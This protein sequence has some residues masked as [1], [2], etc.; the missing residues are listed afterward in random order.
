MRGSSTLVLTLPR[1][2]SRIHRPCHGRSSA[3]P[4]RLPELPDAHPRADRRGHRRRLRALCREVAALHQAFGGARRS[5]GMVRREQA[6]PVLRVRRDHPLLRRVLLVRALRCA[7]RFHRHPAEARV[8][9]R[10]ALSLPDAEALRWL[11]CAVQ[12]HLTSAW[13]MSIDFEDIHKHVENYQ[14][15]IKAVF[16][17]IIS[18]DMKLDV[19]HV[20]S[21]LFRRRELLITCGMSAIPMRV[22]EGETYAAR[23]ELVIELP[24]GWP[25]NVDAFMD[26]RHYWPVRLL[27]NLARYPMQADSWLGYGHTVANGASDETL[28][29][30]ASNVPFCAA[31]VLP[32]MPMGEN[33]FSMTSQSGEEV[34][35]W[36]VV[37]LHRA[38]LAFKREQGAD[39]LLDL[40]DKRG[41][42]ARVDPA[43]PSVV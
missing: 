12:G 31:A 7:V 9:S 19:L 11:P 16:T 30:Y 17:E 27:K 39:A 18:D 34:I 26:E 10:E 2:E 36:S 6:L 24:R 8:R 14:G 21:T 32:C 28:Q 35:F 4:T 20:G 37:P 29:P 5:I 33:G 38:E 42:R 40:F 15:P 25:L 22:P 1:A 3:H 41:V 23:A 43:R 13:P